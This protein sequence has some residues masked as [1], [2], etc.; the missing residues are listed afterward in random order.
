MADSSPQPVLL[1]ATEGEWAGRSLESV[2]A[3]RGYAVLRTQSG[4]SAL[5]LA[6]RARPDAVIIDENM[7]EISGI[8]LCRRLRNDPTFDAATPVIMMAGAPGSMSDRA[9]A[10]AAGAWSVVTHP[11]DTDVLLHELATFIRAKRA[12][13]AA[14]H[15]SLIDPT[16]GLLNPVGLERWVEQL[17]ARAARNHEPLA[18]VVLNAPSAAGAGNEDDLAA[19]AAAFVES[20]RGHIRRSDVV[21]VTSE[22]QLAVIAPDTNDVGAVGLVERLRKAIE[23]GAAAELPGQR[24]AMGFHAGYCAI[25]DFS[26]SDVS[27]GELL[28]RATRAVDH[29]NRLPNGVLTLGFDDLPVS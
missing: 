13:A 28:A 25:D 17:A 3:G 9:E 12:V 8:E 26:R 1:I 5:Q 6:H 19:V 14:E 15:R 4:R 2:L 11:L 24:D 27:A 10:Y 21:G 20:S 18:C 16:T 22:G 29:L 23:E 7:Q